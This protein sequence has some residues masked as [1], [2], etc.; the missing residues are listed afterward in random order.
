MDMDILIVDDETPIRE[1]IQF[2]I[3]HADDERFTVIGSARNGKEAYDL[4]REKHP[5]IVISDI[6]MPVMDGVELLRKISEEQP[7]TAFIILTNHAE[8]TY[9]QKAVSYGARRYLLKSELRGEELMA[10][11][12]A[13]YEEQQKAEA[14]SAKPSAEVEEKEESAENKVLLPDAPQQPYSRVIQ[15]VLTYLEDHYMEEISLVNVAR[16]VYRS[17]EYLSRLFK[18]ETGENFSVY[19]MML[20]MKKARELLQTTDLKI[21]QVAYEVGYETPGYFTKIYRKYMG[22]SPEDTRYQFRHQLSK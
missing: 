12:S 11:L 1:W 18:A 4:F 21:Y 16:H 14:R 22:E 6:R 17:S 9:A 7:D 19:L 3:G 5:Q 8:F 10:E 15:D 20:R 13:V 2:C